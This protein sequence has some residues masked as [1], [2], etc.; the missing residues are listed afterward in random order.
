M[1]LNF[2]GGLIY[3]DFCLVYK[4][5]Y[6]AIILYFRIWLFAVFRLGCEYDVKHAVASI[7]DAFYH[8][9]ERIILKKQ[10][11]YFYT[12]YIYIEK[13]YDRHIRIASYSFP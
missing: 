4:I 11:I 9:T 2:L 10:Q 6:K 3:L 7:D 1:N 8:M 13:F 12:L 5:L